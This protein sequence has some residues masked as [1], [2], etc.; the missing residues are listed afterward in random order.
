MPYMNSRELFEKRLANLEKKILDGAGVQPKW[1]DGTPEKLSSIVAATRWDE[2]LH[3]RGRDGKFI[4]KFGFVRG[5]FNWLKDA[6][7][8]A[9]PRASGTKAEAARAKIVGFSTDNGGS[10]DNPWVKVE[11]DGPDKKLQGLVGYARANEVSS[12]ADLKAKLGLD[13]E[14]IG[15]PNKPEER[16]LNEITGKGRSHPPLDKSGKP[17][18]FDQANRPLTPDDISAVYETDEIPIDVASVD[19]ALEQLAAGHK[20]NFPSQTDVTILLDKMVEVVNDAKER[21]D[22]APNYNLCAVTVALVSLFCAEHKGIPRVQMPQLAGTPV[23]GSRADSM[24]KSKNGTVD[25]TAQFR[26]HL[27]SKGVAVVDTSIRADHLKASQNELNGPKVA[28]IARAIEAGEF[29]PND[30]RIFVSSDNYVVDGHHRWAATAANGYESGEQIDLDVSQVDMEIIELLAEA[31]NFA[32]EMGI[33]QQ[34]MADASSKPE[35][36]PPKV[37]DRESKSYGLHYDGWFEGHPIVQRAR[38]SDQW[39]DLPVETVDPKELIAIEKMLSSRSIDKVVSGEV[40]LRTGYTVQVVRLDDGRMIIADGH[41]RAAMAAAMDRPLEVKIL[42]A[43]ALDLSDMPE[44]TRAT[45]PH[46]WL[47]DVYQHHRLADRVEAQVAAVEAIEPEVTKALQDLSSQFDGEMVGL[48]FRF[49]EPKGILEKIIRKAVSATSLPETELSDDDLAEIKINDALRYTVSLPS[50]RYADGVKAIIQE[51]RELGFEIP[52]SAVKNSWYQHDGYNGINAT[53]TDP[54]SGQQVEL[55]FHTPES[56][57]MKESGTHADYEIVRVMSNVERERRAAYERMVELADSIPM[58]AEA[59]VTGIGTPVTRPFQ[60][61]PTPVFGPAVVRRPP[62]TP[63]V[64]GEPA[65]PG[66]AGAPGGGGGPVAASASSIRH[67][68]RNR[69]HSGVRERD[70][71]QK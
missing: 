30:D 58:P 16:L 67:Q 6:G 52:D 66:G 37:L 68:L 57:Y 71:S 35:A 31:N 3:P 17:I 65:A 63:Q 40:P 5:L 19:E 15:L 14:P 28:G 27:E 61:N 44:R 50:N 70:R 64:G 8:S 23:P 13:E 47:P 25:L 34:D 26:E 12:V 38:E 32:K 59:D 56:F 69:V 43:S 24:K 2:A 11:Y 22:S 33:A 10:V 55:Q 62:D 20:V 46:L 53:F 21:G 1:G 48:P 42:D 41:H 7:D 60:E 29:N 49:K 39:D 51:L 18:Y 36:K 4:E 54:K 45:D 9:D